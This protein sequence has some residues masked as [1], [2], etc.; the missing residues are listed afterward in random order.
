MLEQKKYSFNQSSAS[1]EVFGLPDLSQSSDNSISI[2]SNWKLSINNQPEIEGNIDHLRSIINAFYKYSNLILLGE[3]Q[4][5]ESKLVDIKLEDGY[6]DICLKSTKKEVEPLTLRIGNA[7]LCD[8]VS[9]FDQLN[10]SQDINLN[11]RDL[12]PLTKNS[13]FKYFNINNIMDTITP[14]VMALL[15]ILFFSLISSYFYEN[16]TESNENV[17]FI[18][19]NKGSNISKFVI[20]IE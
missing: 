6:H 1:L 14:P 16:K 11:F 10:S 15:S 9:C 8:I 20:R 17:S 18:R 12:I 4:I 2:I 13:K 3:D 7:E 5:I 19:S